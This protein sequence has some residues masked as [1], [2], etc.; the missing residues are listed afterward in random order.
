MPALPVQIY[1]NINYFKF[2]SYI[3]YNPICKPVLQEITV[4]T[5]VWNVILK[6]FTTNQ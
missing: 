4:Y 3:K 5:D 1:F 2:S 6:I